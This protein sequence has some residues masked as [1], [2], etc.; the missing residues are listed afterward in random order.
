[1]AQIGHVLSYALRYGGASW[2]IQSGGTHAYFPEL[3]KAGVGFLAAGLLG[4]LL[5]IGAGRIFLGERLGYQRR[6]GIPLFDLV[7]A[8]FCLQLDVY[9]VQEILEA[10]ASGQD[11]SLQLMAT[12][13]AWGL[14]GQAPLALLAALALHWLSTRLELVIGRLRWVLARAALDVPPLLATPLP[15]PPLGPCSLDQV[16]LTVSPT[17]GPPTIR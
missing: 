11:L 12:V 2:A 5:L 10:V 4:A 8:C 15:R 17:R 13:V 3:L 6:C 9:I 7:V 14:I 16:A 1:M